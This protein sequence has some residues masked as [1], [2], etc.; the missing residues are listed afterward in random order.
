MGA[1][2]VREVSDPSGLMARQYSS[3]NSDILLGN[4][5][6][7]VK[8]V[9]SSSKEQ[10][11]VNIPPIMNNCCTSSGSLP[12]RPYTLTMKRNQKA[13]K[14]VL[15]PSICKPESPR[16]QMQDFVTDPHS[17]FGWL[18]CVIPLLLSV[19]HF[20]GHALLFLPGLPAQ[21]LSSG[22]QTRLRGSRLRTEAR[23]AGNEGA[24]IVAQNAPL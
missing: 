12:G 22:H 1:H 5:D 7:H 4:L 24:L 11:C 18:V 17:Y 16:R 21:R 3:L 9:S 14:R 20:A 6:N 23:R 8:A 13:T 10:L 15:E 19:L 2:G